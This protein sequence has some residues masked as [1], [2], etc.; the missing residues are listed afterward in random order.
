MLSITN[1]VGYVDSLQE[2]VT[3]KLGDHGV[4]GNGMDTFQYIPLL[5]G[6]R[7]LLSHPII[8]DEVIP[9]GHSECYVVLQNSSFCLIGL[10]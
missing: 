9:V 7:A 5:P 3:K 8:F 2:P 1:K 10:S 6:L 4:R